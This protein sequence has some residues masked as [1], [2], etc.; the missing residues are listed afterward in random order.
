MQLQK[1]ITVLIVLLSLILVGVVGIGAWFYMNRPASVPAETP[2]EEIPLPPDGEIPSAPVPQQPVSQNPNETATE[3]DSEEQYA[4]LFDSVGAIRIDFALATSGEIYNLY[5]DQVELAKQVDPNAGEF[6][7][8][9]AMHDLNNDKVHEA[10][11][12]NAMPGF[13]GSG[14]C[15][16]HV[17][18]KGSAGWENIYEG[19]AYDTVGVTESTTGD[20]KNLLLS[21]HGGV[22]YMTQVLQFIFKDEA[23]QRWNLVA[24]WNGERFVIPQ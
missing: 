18:R 9:I 22:G 23:Y 17:W 7:I 24:V 5:A 15:S 19:L 3:A 11:V 2:N 6:A 13:C 10:I 20:Y 4:L 1:I 14:G 21:V 8:Q 12:Y 16:F